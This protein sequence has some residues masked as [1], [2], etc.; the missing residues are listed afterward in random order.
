MSVFVSQKIGQFLG[1]VDPVKIFISST[2][3]TVQKLVVDVKKVVRKIGELGLS[4]PLRIGN[5]PDL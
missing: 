1:V 4:L 3:I 5:V 2:L